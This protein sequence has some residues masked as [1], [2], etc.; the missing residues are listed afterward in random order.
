M[1]P[2]PEPAVD[3]KHGE[4]CSCATPEGKL[5]LYRGEA[6][7]AVDLPAP[8]TAPRPLETEACA[9]HSGKF[10]VIVV[11]SL[12]AAELEN[13]ITIT[14]TSLAERNG[15]VDSPFFVGKVRDIN[16]LLVMWKCETRDRHKAKQLEVPEHATRELLTVTKGG[17]QQM[18]LIRILMSFT[19]RCSATYSNL[20]ARL[21]G[22]DQDTEDSYS[23]DQALDIVSAWGVQ[24]FTSYVEDAKYK[25]HKGEKL[26]SLEDRCLVSRATLMEVVKLR[27]DAGDYVYYVGASGEGCNG[28]RL[29]KHPYSPYRLYRPFWGT[30]PGRGPYRPYIPYRPISVSVGRCS[31]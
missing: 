14:L 23:Y 8:Q 5:A 21:V 12:H 19:E 10:W 11:V 2:A 16:E 28:P 20:S 6:V 9:S 25:K 7:C 29:C 17:S 22:A 3:V 18:K 13:D 26:S 4:V 30:L 1:Q 15:I 27:E 31:L 24:R